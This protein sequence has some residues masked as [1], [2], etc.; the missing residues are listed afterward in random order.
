LIRKETVE[1]FVRK[2]VHSRASFQ[3]W[4]TKLKHADWEIPGDIVGSFPTADLLGKGSNRV[5]FDVSGNRFRLVAR[6]AFGESMVHLF[7][8]W[9]GTHAEYDR[10]CRTG[11]QYTVRHH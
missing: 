7:V 11:G 3:E 5:V 8:C 1:I 2:N 9:I 10:L 4:L 6:Y